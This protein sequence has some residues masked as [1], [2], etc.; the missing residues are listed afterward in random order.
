MAKLTATPAAKWKRTTETVQL[1]SGN[2]AELKR[3]NTISLIMEDDNIPDQLT[4][5]VL[6]KI[7]GGPDGTINAENRKPV[8]QL[9]RLVAKE[10]FVNPRIV[11]GEPDYDAGEIAI[12]DVDDFDLFA[13][14]EWAVSAGGSFRS[15]AAAAAKQS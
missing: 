2:I 7:N 4:N 8:M 14:L 1:P 5:F 15:G 6:G 11:E 13:V 3:P 9:A 12:T 10:A